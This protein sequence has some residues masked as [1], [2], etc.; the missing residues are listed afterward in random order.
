MNELQTI[1]LSIL[2]IEVSYL[3]YKLSKSAGIGKKQLRKVF[4][5]TSVLI[6]GRILFVAEA[7]FLGG[8]KIYI[9]RSVI[10]ELQ[11]IAD[12]SDSE[13]RAKARRGLDNLSE[14]QAIKNIDI[15]IFQDESEAREGVD[16]RLLHLAKKYKSSICT[17]DFNLIKVAKAESIEV[18]NINDLAMN[19]RMSYLPGE[20][21]E[22]VLGQKGSERDQ[23]IG[24][25]P[26]G[27]MVV[28]EN[29]A[30][31][32]GK[33]VKVETTRSLQTAAGR[34]IFARLAK[35]TANYSKKQQT[36][37]TTQEDRMVHLA[38]K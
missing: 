12:T 30:K 11:L 23:A 3:L 15:E 20:N 4:V 25:L 17:I 35:K 32:I 31:F 36:K 7:G 6:D 9:P 13:K 26:D 16:E 8:S 28:V 10:R 27:T 1:I 22:V 21:F 37:K 19:L 38:N 29:S 34:M 2:L 33:S 18:L 24:H 14:L 5:D